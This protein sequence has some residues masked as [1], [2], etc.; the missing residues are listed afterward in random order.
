ML[1]LPQGWVDVGHGV[2]P[3]LAGDDQLHLG[4]EKLI[5]QK[6]LLT[7]KICVECSQQRHIIKEIGLKKKNKV[8]LYLGQAN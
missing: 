8:S 4:T 2:A 6:I 3:H 1:L 7:L 5:F